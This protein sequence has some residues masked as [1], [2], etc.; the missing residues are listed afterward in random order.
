[1][2][3][4]FK[5]MGLLAMLLASTSVGLHAAPTPFSEATE[6]TQLMNNAELIGIGKL[7]MEQV[8]LQVDQLKA[9][10]DLVQ[11]QLKAYENMIQ[12]TLNLPETVWGDV[13]KTLGQLRSVYSQ[14]NTLAM[15]GAQIDEFLKQGLVDDPL[16]AQSGYSRDAYAER[17]D[18]WVERSQAALEGTLQSGRL[19]MEDV[20][21]E[22]AMIERIQDQ[23]RTVK[24]QVEAIQV[25]NELAASMARQMTQLRSITAAQNE[26]TAVF[27]AR[28]LADMDADEASK[29]SAME[30]AKAI[31]TEGGMNLFGRFTSR[32]YEQSR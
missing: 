24:G 29:R 17:Y 16:F 13:T 11:G 9:Q 6:M 3:K 15:K 1:M 8:G 12:N 27:Q 32:A 4:V 5:T 26:A 28:M 10:L 25:G 2:T 14:A 19:T 30:A 22:A 7:E 31:P 18:D 23:G 20:Q 21:S